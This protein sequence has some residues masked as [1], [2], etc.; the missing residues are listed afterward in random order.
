MKDLANNAYPKANKKKARMY[1]IH[2]Y[3]K[4]NDSRINEVNGI[5]TF[6]SVRT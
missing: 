2:V 4:T 6:V 3:L 5:S 1:R